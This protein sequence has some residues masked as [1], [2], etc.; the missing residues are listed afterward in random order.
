MSGIGAICNSS[1]YNGPN[2]Q[3]IKLK[4]IFPPPEL[5]SPSIVKKLQINLQQDMNGIGEAFPNLELLNVEGHA[6]STVAS[7]EQRHFEHMTNLKALAFPYA[8]KTKVIG[9]FAFNELVN[10]EFLAFRETGVEFFPENVFWNLH[11]LKVLISLGNP[12]RVI[13]ESLLRDLTELEV[14]TLGNSN[15]NV[16]SKNVFTRLRKLKALDLSYNPI[17]TLDEEVF[18][19]LRN[20]KGLRLYGC[21]LESL[22]AKLFENNLKLETILLYSNRLKAIQVVFSK[23][24]MIQEVDLTNNLC[25]DESYSLETD[26]EIITIQSPQELDSIIRDKCV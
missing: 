11:K 18:K 21:K 6:D 26:E 9:E 7:I 15:I 23:L 10:L 16:L 5:R 25:I 4:P 1:S 19:D 22:P 17:S 24:K 2:A 13:H 12:F 8:K 20:L 3:N 14:L